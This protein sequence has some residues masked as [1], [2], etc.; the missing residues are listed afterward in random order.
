[1]E[2]CDSDREAKS[3]RVCFVHDVPVW[4]E[5][6]LDGERGVVGLFDYS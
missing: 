5:A 6:L 3:D 4:L 1:M 2:D